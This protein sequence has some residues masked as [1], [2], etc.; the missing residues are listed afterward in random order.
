M[1]D[2][3]IQVTPDGP[4][5]VREL[6]TLVGRDGEALETRPS[7][8]LCRCGGSANK[9]F[10]DGTHT[11]LE[12]SG[13]KQGPSGKD[14]RRS[15]EGAGITVHDTR[16]ACCH[17]GECVRGAPG[18]FRRDGRPWIDPDGESP[19]AIQAVI[20]RCPSGALSFTRDGEEYAGETAEPSVHVTPDGPLEVHGGI[21]LQGAEFS[22]GQVTEHYT[23]CRCGA[24]R[25]KPFCDGSHVEAEFRG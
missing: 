21:P 19:D 22:A 7:L 2:P 10:C 3:R 1:S 5:L 16:R 23:L 14:A 12:F 20:R 13:E 24:S 8:A 9:P 17:A 15:Y 11:A 6:D 25:N 18:A 4:F